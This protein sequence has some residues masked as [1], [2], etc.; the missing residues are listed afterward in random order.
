MISLSDLVALAKAGYGPKQVKEL[1]EVFQTDPKVKG[2]KIETDD[3]GKPEIKEDPKPADPKEDPKP[4]EGG[5]DDDIA[6]LIKLI[7]ED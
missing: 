5:K 2:A 1:I 6:E 7:K 3:Q 4:A